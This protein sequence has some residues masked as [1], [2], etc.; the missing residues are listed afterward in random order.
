MTTLRRHNTRSR[1]LA[2]IALLV[3]AYICNT[4]VLYCHVLGNCNFVLSLANSIE[5]LM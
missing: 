3:E 5:T 1:I 4:T 2:Y